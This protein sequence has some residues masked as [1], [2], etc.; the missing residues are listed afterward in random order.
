[1]LSVADYKW[2]STWVHLAIAKLNFGSPKG[3]EESHS[4][5]PEQM[6]K[7]PVAPAVPVPLP[8][9]SVLVSLQPC[10]APTTLSPG[11]A[12]PVHPL[13]HII[14]SSVRPSSAG[15]GVVSSAVVHTL[16]ASTP[17]PAFKVCCGCLQR[18]NLCALQCLPCH[19]THLQCIANVVPPFN[20]CDHC[21]WKGF[22]CVPA[23]HKLGSCSSHSLPNVPP[24]DEPVPLP[25]QSLVP[26]LA[27]HMSEIECLGHMAF[28]HREVGHAKA[29][30]DSGHEYLMLAQHMYAMELGEV[31][32]DCSCLTLW[33]CAASKGKG[34]EVVNIIY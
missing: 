29:I 31:V 28:W 25:L 3:S 5:S 2:F 17:V 27:A 8:A 14:Y 12:T 21:R 24:P 7:V 32:A 16:N 19:T 13:P 30:I 33:G 20:L 4:E 1:M 11:I 10:A 26:D 15:A 22:K 34:K 6:E 18:S 9:V 23:P